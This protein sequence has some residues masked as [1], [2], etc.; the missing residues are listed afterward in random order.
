MPN[1]TQTAFLEALGWTLLNSWWQL[2]IL[3]VLFLFL[4]KVLPRLYASTRYSFA[5]AF[6]L[7]GMA[8]SLISFFLRWSHPFT[9][10]SY[11]TRINNNGI[12]S[13]YGLLMEYTRVFLPYLS[14]VYLAWLTVRIIRFSRLYLGSNQLRTDGLHKAP[15]DWRLFLE[16]MCGQMNIKRKV[17]IWLSDKVDTPVLMGWLKPMV[18]LPFSAISQ[19]NPDQ[20]EAILIHELAHVRRNDFFWNIVVSLS[21]MI[22]FF[23]PFARQ[24]VA[25]I[26]EER[27]HACDDWVLQFP[28]KPEMYA[29][30][31]LKLEQQRTLPSS[32]I[33]L[34]ARGSSANLL[35][36]RVKR[37]LQLPTNKREP[38][39]KLALLTA[40]FAIVTV[41]ALVEPREEIKTFVWQVVS[42][43]IAS[44][45]NRV[46]NLRYETPEEGI[47]SK[48]QAIPVKA[49]ATIVRR[50]KANTGDQENDPS[51][52]NEPEEEPTHSALAIA[53]QADWIKATN[54]GQ[55]DYDYSYSPSVSVHPVERAYALPEPESPAPPLDAIQE[56]YMP[57]VPLK[58]FEAATLSMDTVRVHARADKQKKVTSQQ[59]KKA[60]L[61][62]QVAL[63][64]LNWGKLKTK[65]SSVGVSA[66]N[67][68]YELEK[69]LA[70]LDWNKI[71]KEAS[72]A[73]DNLQK[74]AE[75]A[76]EKLQEIQQLSSDCNLSAAVESVTDET[77]AIVR[78]RQKA[79]E[80]QKT[81]ARRPAPK[82]TVYF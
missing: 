63:D 51:A 52:A 43:P 59:A 28:F 19:L 76:Q 3:W 15:V 64:Q 72:R 6:L 65:L 57:Y 53:D 13:A 77:E 73:L 67:I 26:R 60:A 24:L 32:D 27:E 33:L 49:V 10:T 12:Y 68:Q 66:Q 54:T 20:L 37:M 81:D 40:C 74:K 11:L 75:S 79:V 1:Q 7:I 36:T 22:F 44:L 31:L 46:S 30:A 38:L 16:N 50:T 58:S 71:E 48:D 45:E 23:N 47:S 56:D 5:L 80:K 82:S 34:A 70:K 14:M 62:V 2:G 39:G 17:S 9:E 42:E 41:L 21:E 35:L 18:L 25:V 4:K 29:T 78:K 61:Q 55:V 69:E 8:W